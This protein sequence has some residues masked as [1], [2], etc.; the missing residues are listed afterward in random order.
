MH[1][2]ASPFTTE[3]VEAIAAGVAADPKAPA[4]EWYVR[5]G[6]VWQASHPVVK[7]HPEWFVELG[8]AQ[9]TPAYMPGRVA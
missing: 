8:Q 3:N 1:K 6:T 2:T 7:A 9:T 4:G 5:M